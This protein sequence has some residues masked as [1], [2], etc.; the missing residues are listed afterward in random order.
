MDRRR[1]VGVVLVL[2]S[3]CAFGSGGLFAQP[4][5]DTGVGWQTL[6]AWRFGFG[7]LCA[8]LWC[9]AWADRRRGLRLLDRRAVLVAVAL[10]VLYTGNSGTYYAGLE[11]V[12]V[13]LAA[14]IVYIY[15]AVVAVLSLRYGRR[16]EGRRAWFALGLALVGV[17][18]AVGGIPDDALPPIA[19]LVLIV[20]SPL[21]YSVWIILSARLAGE[22]K[23]AVG[24]AGAGGADAAAATA[25]MMTGTAA[26]YWVTSLASGVPLAPAEIPSAAWPGL[27]G[28]GVVATFVAIQT[29]YAGAK[30]VGAAQAALVSTIEPFYT[31]ALAAILFG[32]SLAPVQLAGGALIILGVLI[33]QAPAE[34]FSSIRPGV[35]IADE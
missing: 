15:P 31:I 1:L 32:E 24:D 7:A 17:A 19:G 2:V 30:R 23:E 25:L 29:F 9:L 5:Y 11:T 14:L 13:S 8:W 3:A 26:T 22:R 35:R 16:L 10:G 18:L 33:A 28:V 27:V 12:P 4:V 34:A 21:I 6:S 20:V